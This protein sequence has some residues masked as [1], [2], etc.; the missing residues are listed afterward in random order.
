MRTFRSLSVCCILSLLACKQAAAPSGPAPAAAPAAETAK[1][2]AGNGGIKVGVLTDMTGA[3]SDLAGKGSVLA[4][5]MAIEDFG[6]QLLGKP[7]ELV[8]ADHQNKA[9]ISSNIARKWFDEEGVSVIADLVSSSTAL[10]VMPLAKAKNKITL[11]SGPG[12]S[13]ITNE[14]CTDTNVHWAYD[15]HA[16]AVGTGREVVKQGGDS[17]FFITA[18]Y[19][20]GHAMEAE[21]SKIVKASGGKV[22][23]SVK[24]PVGTMDF[25]SFLFQA[26]SSGA[27]VI[28]LANAS[29]DTVTSIKQAREFKIGEGNQKLAVLIFY[30]T[31]VHALG[32]EATQGVQYL[33]G[34]YWDRDDASRAFGKRFAE[35][36]GGK[37][38]TQAQAVV[39]SAVKH[40]LKAVDAANSTDG[41]T[42]MRKMKE[43]PVD[44]FFAAP[45]SKVRADGRLMNGYWL[46]E[47]KKPA[48]VKQGWDLLTIKG[49]VNA[50]DVMRPIADGGCTHLD[51]KP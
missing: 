17:W 34:Y 42:V 29:G 12:S 40:Y 9:D 45:G 2:P 26:Q 47:V 44:D 41:L 27:K 24:H 21:V 5:Q 33:T 48:D 25:S 30:L 8:S 37:M 13:K 14:A 35:K 3:Y 11:L 4:A 32:A 6:G 1:P 7:I 36:S 18:D 38:P 50:E 23:G 15:T 22:L 19:A 28:A 16:L 10:A 39:Y 31:S 20:F 51:P 43:M 49:R 46:A